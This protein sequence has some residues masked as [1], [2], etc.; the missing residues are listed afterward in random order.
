[1]K[2]ILG[3]CLNWKAAA[4][5]GAIG[6]AVWI[7]APGLIAA[8]LPLL[9]LALCPLS[10]AIMGWNMRGGMAEH[11]NAEPAGRLAELEREQARLTAEI[12]QVRAQQSATPERAPQRPERTV[13]AKG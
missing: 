2:N 13:E 11:G 4:V 9:I 6:L 5:L 7:Y 12:A 10:M 1:M 8:A 3:M